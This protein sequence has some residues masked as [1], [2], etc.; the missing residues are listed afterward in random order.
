MLFLIS[1]SSVNNEVDYN[2]YDTTDAQSI[3]IPKAILGT[4]AVGID[5]FKY[6]W[7]D[8]ISSKPK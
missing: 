3:N 6:R 8:D 4:D 2:I 5:Y 1:Y 7:F